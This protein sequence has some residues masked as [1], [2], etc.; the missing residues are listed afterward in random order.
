MTENADI[1][2]S[3]SSAGKVLCCIAAGKDM[4]KLDIRRGTGLSMTTVISSVEALTKRGLVTFEEVKGARGGKMRSV[5]NVQETRRAY[6]VSYKSGVLTAVAVDLRGE[7]REVTVE[8]PPDGISPLG[9]V[10]AI[11][12]TLRKKAPPPIAV[13]LSLNC[14]GK[15]EVLTELGERYRVPTVSLTNTEAAACLGLWRGAPAPVAALGLGSRVKCALAGAECR[16]V[17]EVGALP[18]PALMAGEG[19]YASALSAQAVEETLRTS[20]YHGKYRLERG[21][22]TE[23]RDLADYSAALALT[24]S[25]LVS[26]VDLL[27]SPSRIL[28]F[29]DY[30]TEAFCD[31]IKDSSGKVVYARFGKEDFALG[32]AICALKECVFS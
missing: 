17:T 20:R 22:I 4:T 1:I 16:R 30:L 2:Q 19:S 25:S 26:T 9:R 23:V 28:L 5:I 18:S 13:A 10:F 8:E 32:A 11:V 12:N 31:R 24:L 3:F 27:L 29:G 6:G 15:E 7:M 21:R 14:A